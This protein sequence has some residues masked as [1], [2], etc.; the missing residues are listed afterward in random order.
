MHK[1]IITKTQ[2]FWLED[3]KLNHLGRVETIEKDLHKIAKLIGNTVNTVPIANPSK[4]APYQEY[5]TPQARDNILKLYEC[6][7]KTFE[8]SEEL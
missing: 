5:Y 7:F 8:Y 1:D 6:D 4:H 3:V 2:C